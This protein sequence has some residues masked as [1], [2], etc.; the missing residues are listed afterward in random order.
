MHQPVD[1]VRATRAVVDLDAVDWNVRHFREW[2]RAPHF[3]TVVKADAYGHGAAQI[4]R[5]AVSAGADHVGVYAVNEGVALRRGGIEAPI[6]VFGPFTAHEAVLAVRHDLMLTITSPEAAI[7]LAE[8]GLKVTVHVK[9]D[10]GLARSGVLPDEVGRAL[11]VLAD[12]GTVRVRG[13]FTHFA[14]ADEQDKRLTYDQLSRFLQGAQQ[15]GT[16]GLGGLCLHAANTAA[17]L[18]VPESHLDMV[19]VGIGTYGYY[20]SAN[21]HRPFILRPVLSLASSL[22]R[23][24]LEP[25]GVGV[26]Y[27]HEFVCP[28]PTILGLV[29]I[30]YGDGLDRRLGHGRGQVLVRGQAVPIVGR[31]SMDQITVDLTEVPRVQVGDSVTVIGQ[32]GAAAQTAEDLGHAAGTISYD[33]L[34]GLLPRVPRVYTRGGAVVAV[35]DLDRDDR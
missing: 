13:L 28:R 30:G 5:A 23:V 34:T 22:T 17:T 27:G 10:T 35:R 2:S 31:V 33:V 21:V 8:S 6:L 9:V 29:P 14:S 12:A 7:T 19:R 15:A 1:D 25:P 16:R 4:A 11:S 20:P 26:G 18:D 32:D 24:H 3:M